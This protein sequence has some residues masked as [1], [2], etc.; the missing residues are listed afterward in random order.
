M[1]LIGKQTDTFLEFLK[2]YEA[3]LEKWKKS[4][5]IHLTIFDYFS[6]IK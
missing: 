1:K 3:S 2:Q 6:K 5:Y 4:G